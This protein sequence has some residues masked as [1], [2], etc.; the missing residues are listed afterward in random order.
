MAIPM[1]SA[2]DM[3]AD[4]FTAMILR[5]IAVDIQVRIENNKL[6]IS[7]YLKDKEVRADGKQN[8]PGPMCVTT[9][10]LDLDIAATPAPVQRATFRDNWSF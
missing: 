8:P 1:D 5:R 2:A 10:L 4:D 9:L 7:S 6:V 3:F